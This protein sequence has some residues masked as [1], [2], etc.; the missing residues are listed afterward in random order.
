MFI[1]LLSYV[2]LLAIVDDDDTYKSFIASTCVANGRSLAGA[3][4]ARRRGQQRMYK[5]RRRV[6]RVQSGSDIPRDEYVRTVPRIF[7][8]L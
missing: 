1:T 7:V 5:R 8:P 6:E 2:E 3:E 4:G